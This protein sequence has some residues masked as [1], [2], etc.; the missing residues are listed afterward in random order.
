MVQNLLFL[1]SLQFSLQARACPDCRSWFVRSSGQHSEKK[2][3]FFIY[4]RTCTFFSERRHIVRM[5]NNLSDKQ[6]DYLRNTTPVVYQL[7]IR[8]IIYISYY[9]NWSHEIT[10]QSD[11]FIS[12]IINCIASHHLC[13]DN[14]QQQNTH[15]P[16][17]NKT[18][19][20]PLTKHPPFPQQ[21]NTHH[22]LNNKTP[23]IPLTTKHPPFP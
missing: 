21:Q 16:L 23:T 17:D 3:G 6:D 15:H 2:K 5:S 8:N 9:P 4:Y 13:Q 10:L 19:T 14:Y 11:I 7:P 18:P 20:I 12:C 1:H 22:S